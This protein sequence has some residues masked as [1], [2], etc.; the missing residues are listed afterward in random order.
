[1]KFIMP[2][3]KS[4]VTSILSILPG[5]GSTPANLFQEGESIPGSTTSILFMGILIVVIILIPIIWERRQ[6]MR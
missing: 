3:L 2:L 1:M 5:N 4:L 6:W